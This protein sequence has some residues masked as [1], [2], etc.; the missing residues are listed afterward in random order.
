VH[1][2]HAMTAVLLVSRLCW[3]SF[4]HSLFVS[5]GKLKIYL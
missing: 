1:Y 2:A 5:L 3:W 4:G